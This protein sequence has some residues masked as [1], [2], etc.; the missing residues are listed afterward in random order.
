[1]SETG[2]S[3]LISII[4]P[5]YNSEQSIAACVSSVLAQTYTDFELIIVNDASDDST[6]EICHSLTEKDSRITVIDNLINCGVLVSRLKGAEA[7]KSEWIAFIDADDLWQPEKL[8]K[9]I[10]LRDETGCDLV[11]TGSAF[12][13]EKGR[14]YDWVM[15]V[16]SSV[17]YKRLLK[18]NVISNSS[19]LMRRQDF[20]D[21][22][23][24]RG[25]NGS[26]PK[27]DIH[28]DYACWL[29]MLRAGKVARGIDEP[30]IT[31]RLSR[32]SRAGNKF[33]AAVMNMNTYKYIGLGFFERIGYEACY[34]VNGLIKY[35]HFL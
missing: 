31:Y 16:P 3:E 5:V 1:M 29:S 12:A 34:A 35:G 32:N 18:Q 17:E 10:R 19:V 15:H 13:N 26:T 24:T 22:A 4:L 21:H 2:R 9:Q 25:S 28:E 8:E 7:A 11:Y 23:P 6:H 20:I 14:M 27:G 33:K 30:L